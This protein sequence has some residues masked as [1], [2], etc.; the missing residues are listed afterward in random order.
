M[1]AAFVGLRAAV[2]LALALSRTRGPRPG[3]YNTDHGRGWN[4]HFI[5][6]VTG[7]RRRRIWKMFC[8]PSLFLSTVRPVLNRRSLCLVAG[9]GWCL[10]NIVGRCPP[11]GSLR[12]RYLF[13]HCP[14]PGCPSF[15]R[16]ASRHLT[17]DPYRRLF[18]G[19]YLCPLSLLYQSRSKGLVRLLH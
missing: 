3:R 16:M 19:R 11:N 13:G 10:G 8:L 18:V 12:G 6:F 7:N 15:Y 9:R 2:A 4:C 5:Y 17:S 14:L 1:K